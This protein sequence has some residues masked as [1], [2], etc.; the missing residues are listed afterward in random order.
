MPFLSETMGKAKKMNAEKL[1][2]IW[3]QSFRG[4]LSKS[5]W[6]N[7]E[8]EMP[9]F[10]KRVKNT[11]KSKWLINQT[12]AMRKQCRQTRRNRKKNR[13]ENL[14][15]VH[16]R[17]DVTTKLI[18]I[19]VNTVSN[20]KIINQRIMKLWCGWQVKRF[21]SLYL[22]FS[23]EKK[24]DKFWVFVEPVAT[25]EYTMCVCLEPAAFHESL[26][27]SRRI[28]IRQNWGDRR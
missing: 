21:S 8:N 5:L 14:C 28:L 24:H 11:K 7:K 16:I 9:L 26:S 19:I 17:D 27:H 13:R 25:T 23:V 12:A 15:E 2:C 22:P 6:I 3:K 20:T 4:I 1:L 10:Y 18:L